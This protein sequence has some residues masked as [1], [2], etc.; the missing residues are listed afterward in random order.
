MEQID[1]KLLNIGLSIRNLYN[2]LYELDK[3]GKR[4][5]DEY[6][7]IFKY[8]LIYLDSEVEYY[9]ELEF[10]EKDDLIQSFISKMLD[11]ND[12]DL[13]LDN[14]FSKE[15]EKM[16]NI[17]ILLKLLENEYNINIS[18]IDFDNDEVNEFLLTFI[19]FYIK[20]I[21]NDLLMKYNLS[22]MIPQIEKLNVYKE[23]KDETLDEENVIVCNNVDIDT[24]KYV[25]VIAIILNWLSSFKVYDLKDNNKRI[26]FNFYL[27][28]L[29]TCIYHL[30]NYSDIK[31]SVK[32]YSKTSIIAKSIYKAISRSH[33]DKE[34]IDSKIK[35]KI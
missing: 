14:L 11:Y 30:S 17:R 34:Y 35:Y 2:K 28:Y 25:N 5:S 9:S 24:S 16:V 22:F 6:T 1:K 29:R 32:S 15:D 33:L 10:G 26:I 12:G 19:N 18:K 4:D 3:L 23:Y 27:M 20:K 31:F 8:L 21:P 13:I 7:T